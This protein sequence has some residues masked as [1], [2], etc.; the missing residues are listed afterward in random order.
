M[1][2]CELCGDEKSQ[3]DM[4]ED[5]EYCFDCFI[6]SSNCDHCNE[7]IMMDNLEESRGYLFCVDCYDSNHVSNL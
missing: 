4:F 1:G 7:R 2:T 3:E 6:D 5:T